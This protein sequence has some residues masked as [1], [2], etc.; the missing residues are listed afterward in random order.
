M[1]RR[2]FLSTTASALTAAPRVIDDRALVRSSYI[3]QSRPPLTVSVMPILRLLPGGR[4]IC[5]WV[6]G[7]DREPLDINR[8]LISIS[9]NMGRGWTPAREFPTVDGR[10]TFCC[11]IEE[12]NGVATAH[13]FSGRAAD[14]YKVVANHRTVSHDGGRT[15]GALQDYRIVPDGAVLSQRLRL[16]DGAT[17]YPFFTLH[18]KSAVWIHRKGRAPV[19][20]EFVELPGIAL[21]TPRVVESRDGRLVMLLRAQGQGYLFRSESTDGGL[22]WSRAAATAKPSPTTRFWFKTLSDGRHALI[23][24]PTTVGDGGKAGPRDP[25]ELW[26]SEDDM[27]SW[28]RRV[29]LDRGEY[30]HDRPREK[31]RLGYTHQLAYPE[32]VEHQGKLYVAYDYNRRDV[33]FLEADMRRIG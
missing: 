14:R 16:R 8:P 1:R 17:I 33:V 26:L 10:M 18:Q 28:S 19:V 13:L 11:E 4:L 5:V 31:S 30:H 23:D 2:A 15:W 24:N 22:T 21:I 3:F 12:D 27:R 7:G 9:E 25:L 29:V 20:S 32:A 6:S